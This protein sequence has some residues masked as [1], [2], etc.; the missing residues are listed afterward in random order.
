M[1]TTAI[2][3]GIS[4]SGANMTEISGKIACLDVRNL[5]LLRNRIDNLVVPLACVVDYF[6]LKFETQSL[7]PLS[8]NSLVYGSDT[9]GLLFS[10]NDD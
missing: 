1:D 8:I 7:A 4:E 5:A 10:E 2:G 6:G 9:D 3:K